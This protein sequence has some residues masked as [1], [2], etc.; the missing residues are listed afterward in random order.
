M[1]RKSAAVVRHGKEKLNLMP[2]RIFD[3]P[4]PVYCGVASCDFKGHKKELAA[5]KRAV[6]SY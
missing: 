5:H 6:H 2:N 3:M 4:T 1:I